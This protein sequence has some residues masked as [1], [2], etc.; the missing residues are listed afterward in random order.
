MRDG[1]VIVV[2]VLRRPHRV[3]PL[4]E[5]VASATGE[6]RLVF[7]ASEDDGAQIAALEAAGAEFIVCGR[8]ADRGQYGRKINA[9]YEATTEPLLF[10]GADDLSFHANWF[11]NAARC[12]GD[13][14]GVVGT[15][16]LGNPRVRAGLHATHSL[17]T[18]AYCDEFGT[19]DEPH[20]V[21]HEGYWHEY[22][23]TEFVE[24]A[25]AR[26]AWAFA[27]DSIVEHL[28][29]HWGKSPTDELYDAHVKRMRV[30]QRLYVRRR[31]LWRQ[32]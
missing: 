15:N 31:H 27:R 13:G 1:L 23:D 21:L 29:P 24:T 6:Y 9:G 16:D 17:V 28:H 18:R 19:I 4:L 25:M 5:S 3:V 30:G 8:A 22:V 26:G 10:L 20:K 11:E 12:L 7:V 32:P 14:V 2:P